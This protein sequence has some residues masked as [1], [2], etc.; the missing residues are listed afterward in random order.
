MVLAAAERKIYFSKLI[1]YGNAADLNEADFLEYFTLDEDTR[2]IGAYVEGIK[3][4]ER[5]L[6]V[7]RKATRAKPVIILKGGKT[8]AGMEAASSHTGSLAGSQKIWDK[9]CRQ[10]GVV[11]VHN[12]REMIDMFQAF[13]YL[14]PPRGRRAGIIGAGGG[15]NVLAADECE[16]A[17]LVVPALPHDVRQEIRTFT[18][19][20]GTGLR[21]P[22][23]TLMEVYL[24]P[25]LLARTVKLVAE[26]D[27]IDIVFVAFP[28]LLGV[29]LDAQT[30]R[31]GIEAVI[32]VGREKNKPLAFVF[33]TADFGDGEKLAW[34]I[35]G[36]CLDAG[37]PVYWS[38]DRAALSVDRLVTYH[39]NRRV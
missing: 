35:Q 33:R 15:A 8:D 31:D 14:K 1:S 37:F 32:Q 2:I 6:E 16:N 24:D 34:D 5:F 30:L 22:I 28:I 29:K 12:L 17:G 27:G 38:F 11:Q 13:S 25:A 20:A 4:P 18:P 3:R 26:W 7:L 10:I 21:N 36:Q 39:E 23:D 9:L 19:P